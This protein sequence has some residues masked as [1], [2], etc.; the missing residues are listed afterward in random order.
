MKFPPHTLGET[1]FR[2]DHLQ[3]ITLKIAP[4]SD[5][6]TRPLA[7]LVNFSCH[8]F[9]QSY[10]GVAERAYTYK[11]ELRSFNEVR[12]QLSFHLPAIVQALQNA[13]SCFRARQ[14]I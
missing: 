7:I 11:G 3:P 1:T 5:P 9:T 10:D 12:H 13:K 14:I 2:M 6:K 8:C 4:N